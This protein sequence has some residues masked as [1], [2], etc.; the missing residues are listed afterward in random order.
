[1]IDQW[2][3][4]F[5]A[6]ATQPTYRHLVAQTRTLIARE[7][8]A[9]RQP[10]VSFSGGKDSTVLTHLVLRVAPTVT[11]L[12]WDFGRAFVPRPL[13]EQIVQNARALGA[14]RLRIETSPAYEHLGRRARNVLGR[15]LIGWLL[16]RMAQQGYDLSFV[17]LRAEESGKRRRR[18][19][20]GAAL[21][22]IREVW[23]L[24]DWRWLDIWA[25]IVEHNL[26][27]LALY[28][29]AAA[30]VG[31]ATARFTTL[32]DPEFAHLAGATDG[33]LWWRWRH[34]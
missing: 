13:H 3:R 22:A 15:H 19:R 4:T 26:P 23:P 30:I 8:A 7:V 34:S 10:F 18:L 27:Y 17:G 31:Y 33:V 20:A 25:Y 12:H 16:P 24:M 21:S 29:D 14:R 1:V 9:A 2:R 6:W 5:V 28:D 11:V 32:H